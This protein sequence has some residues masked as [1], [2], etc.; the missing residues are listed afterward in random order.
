MDPKGLIPNINAIRNTDWT[1]PQ[2]DK[3]N[4]LVYP[5]FFAIL[6]ALISLLFKWF[7]IEISGYDDDPIEAS[8][9]GITLWYALL[10]VFLIVVAGVSTLYNHNS[11]A[12]WCSVIC[13]FIAIY[14]IFAWPT[15]RLVVDD[16]YNLIDRKEILS[17]MENARG[18]IWY[19]QGFRLGIVPFFLSTLITGVCSLLLCLGVKVKI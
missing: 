2:F 11:I 1:K 19:D 18:F 3:R 14:A 4:V 15:A 9:R 5:I 12:L 8:R 16:Y 13:F 10:G 7:K 6:L 17:L